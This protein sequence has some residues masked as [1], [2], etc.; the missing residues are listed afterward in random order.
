[1][2]RST[3]T[4]LAFDPGGK[5]GWARFDIE[6][7]AITGTT[8]IL[9]SVVD[10][11]WGVL[12]GLENDQVRKMLRMSMRVRDHY[13]ALL[14][15]E[16]SRFAIVTES[17][18]PQKMSR[19]EQFYSPMRINAKLDYKLWEN[20]IDLHYQSSSLAF[21]IVGDT[22]S[23]SDRDARLIERL[24]DWGY[25]VPQKDARAAIAHA[26]TWLRRM[27]NAR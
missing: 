4:A 3:Y 13:L 27:S 26:F 9:D 8:K 5:S 10:W 19:Q 12:T 11:D 23:E 20:G 16:M 18:V 17:F 2:K 24:K 22:V 7:R 1:M 14:H 25:Y 15:P 21:G 6:L